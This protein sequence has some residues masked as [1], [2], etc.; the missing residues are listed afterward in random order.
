MFSEFESVDRERRVTAERRLAAI[1][2][3]LEDQAR[4]DVLERVVEHLEGICGAVA[5][6][7]DRER[8]A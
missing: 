3:V 8:A 2:E 1:V 4:T 6:Q 7:R 5:G